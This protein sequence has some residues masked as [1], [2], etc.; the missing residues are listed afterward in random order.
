MITLDG[1]PLDLT[2]PSTWGASVQLQPNGSVTVVKDGVVTTVKLAKV[3]EPTGFVQSL[4][5]K[6]KY[7]D[8]I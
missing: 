6:G 2:N 3:N 4:N 5:L 1:K 7:H 8:N